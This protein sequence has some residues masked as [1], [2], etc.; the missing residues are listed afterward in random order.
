MN[1]PSPHNKALVSVLF[2][3]FTVIFTVCLIASNI[4]E[5]KQMVFGPLHL[6]GGLLIFPVSYIVN[7]VV[8]EVWGYRR[9]SILIWTGFLTNLAFV[10]VASLADAIPGAP[11]WDNDEGFH[12]I[13]GLT[14]RIALASFISFIAG[15]FVNAY[16]MSRMKISN[17]GKH[18]PLRAIMSTVWGEGADSLCFFPLAFYGVLPDEELPLMMLSQLILKTIYEIIALPVTIRVVKW[19]KAYE[20]EDTYD[21]DVSYN[22]FAVFKKRFSKIP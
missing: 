12:A 3:Q 10:V 20:G 14:P 8:C 19:V 6:T 22:I 15:S 4:L 17:Q 1:S 9:T 13:F 21:H 18:F 16:I 7:D 2:M 11:Y 5:T